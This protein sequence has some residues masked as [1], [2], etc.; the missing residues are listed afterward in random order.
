MSNSSLRVAEAI[1]DELVGMPHEARSSALA[2]RCAGDPAL[3]TLVRNLLDN[4]ADGMGNFLR[5]PALALNRIDGLGAPARIGS[6]EVVREIGRGGGGIVYEAR[7]SNPPRPVALKIIG[8]AYVTAEMLRRFSLEAEIL[9]RLQHPGIA[10]VYEAGTVDVPGAIGSSATAPYFAMELVHG[11]PVTHH[12]DRAELGLR[13]RLVLFGEICNA[14]Q[15][16]HQ[17]GVI[18]RD[19][20]PSNVLVTSA[21]GRPTVKVIDFGI[22]R[23]SAGDSGDQAHITAQLQLIGTPA[24]M[25]PEQAELIGD[26]DTRADIYALGVMLYEILTGRTPLDSHRLRGIAFSEMQRLIVSEAPPLPSVRVSSATGSPVDSP[27]GA[28]PDGSVAKP[29]LSSVEIARRRKSDP[30][31]LARALRG[32]LDWIVMKCLAKDRRERYATV[33]A[34]ADDIGRYLEQQPVSAMPPSATYK[35]RKFARR[36]RGAVIVGVL[37][38]IALLTATGVSISFGVS[39]ARE[40]RAADS[41]TA[42]AQKAEAEAEARADALE[43]VAAF[44]AAQLSGIDARTMGVRLRNDVL[45]MAREA[46]AH[47]QL[48]QDEVDARV[49]DLAD[50]IAGGDFTGLALETLEDTF[51]EPALEA[52]EVEFGDQP[53]LQ[54]QLLQTIASTLRNVGLIA[55]ATAPQ[56]QAL[57]IRRDA[58]GGEHP[59]TLDSITEMGLL[60]RAQGKSAEAEPYYREALEKRQRVLGDE[61]EDTLS[62]LNNMAAL[63][64]AQGK[65]SEAEPF[66]RTALEMRRRILGD[67][68]PDTLTSVAGM[69]YLLQSQGKLDE[70]EPY[71]REALEERRRVLGDEHPHT[72]FA[73]NNMASNLQMQGRFGDAEVLYREA[74][75]KRRRVLGDDHPE[76]LQSMNNLGNVLEAQQR[77]DE[78]EPYYRE[79]LEKRRIVLGDDHPHT[80]NSISGMGAL[81]LNMEKLDEAE[82]YA[83]EALEKRRLI[84][85]DEHPDTL[86]SLNNLAALLD[87][88]GNDLEAEAQFREALAASR[89]LLGDVHPGTSYPVVNLVSLLQEQDR[90][91]EAIELL[92]EFEPA[93]RQN[94]VRPNATRLGRYL[95]VLGRARVAAGDFELA[96]ENLNE[97]YEIFSETEK[98]TDRD[99][100]MV[101]SSLAE[102]FEDWHAF[103]PDEGHDRKAQ[104]WREELAIVQGSTQPAAP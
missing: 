61:H 95:V 40:R 3:L 53:L 74:L 25:S 14:V 62:S 33:S 64:E 63:L 85:G 27:A 15:Y 84:L 68:H 38:T 75:E 91:E 41:A 39:E 87:A 16:A 52:I 93:I 19:L 82:P 1:F 11:E 35:L 36:N 60:L 76:T 26:V 77:L 69:G 47:A 88:Q 49:A 31:Q 45:D 101:L 98:V 6:Y 67:D 55:A 4:D 65:P 18:H 5:R 70:A 71:Y 32:D 103:A 24:Y 79:T 99:R 13:E 89:R 46:A 86:R 81:L 100:V 21:D 92:L 94:F 43:Q 48:P 102:A 22:A 23:A 83:R 51:Y 78:A 59:D 56:T 44:Q 80:L 20:K 66:Y 17:K 12:C 72:L 37:V 2:F 7:Q 29:V 10:Q 90:H 57:E 9:G 30:D 42:R 104:A 96:V 34:L 50:L 73:I 54:A 97:A 8:S 28:A 58:L